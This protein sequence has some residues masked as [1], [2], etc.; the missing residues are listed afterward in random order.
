M[1]TLQ[2]KTVRERASQPLPNP[3]ELSSLRQLINWIARPYEFMDECIETYGDTFTMHL[4]GFRPLVFFSDP[5]S[6]KALFSADAKQ[7]DAGRGQDILRP[8]LGDNSV[9]VMDG[10]RHQRERR[11]LMPP[12]HG[13]KVKSYGEVIC[14]ITSEI[15]DTWKPGEKI[16]A[17][18]KMPEITLEVILQTVFGLREGSRYRQLKIALLDWLSLTAS[19]VSAS[20]LF[21]KWLQKDLGPWSS[22]GK[23]V[24]KRQ[25]VYALLQAEIEQRRADSVA[26]G[27]AAGDDVLSLMLLATDE[28]GQ[29]MTDAELKDELVTMLF[30]GLET[31][32]IVLS[33]ALYWVH[34]LPDVKDKLMAELNALPTD[35]DPMAIA[36][37]PYLSAVASESLRI[38]PV[39]P[40]TSPRIATEATTIGNHTFPAETFIAPAIYAVHHREDLYPDSQVFR[41][42]RFLDRQFSASEFIPFGGGSRRCIGYA[43][44]KLEINLVLA[45]LLKQHSFRL[46]TA[47]AVTPRRRGV[48]LATSN[49]VPLIVQS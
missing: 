33:W 4:F 14:E 24:R 13:A 8:L 5:Q 16:L 47:E 30:A 32:A 31:T 46:A 35:A 17:G 45:T 2:K 1:K 7:F 49:G 18:E 36:S 43:L 21:L 10:A 42:E 37:L 20:V 40:I 19:P 9:I 28:T 39:A 38:Y 25:E 48:V 23:I 15:G 26:E 44:A 34:K 22:W 3:V 12:F 29:S 11:L 6:I 41:P 27:D